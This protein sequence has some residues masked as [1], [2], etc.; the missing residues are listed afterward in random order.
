MVKIKT[1]L[2]DDLRRHT[3]DAQTTLAQL[4]QLVRAAYDIPEAAALQMR[5]LD[6]DG[7]LISLAHDDDLREAFLPVASSGTLRIHLSATEAP[8]VEQKAAKKPKFAEAEMEAPPAHTT[9]LQALRSLAKSLDLDDV[10]DAWLEKH[11]EM[12]T[13]TAP[14]ARQFLSGGTPASPCDVFKHVFKAQQQQQQQHDGQ[15]A[16]DAVHWGV[17][18]DV[19]GMSPIVGVRFHKRGSDYDLC[20]SEF[21]KLS[22]AEQEAFERIEAP[23]MTHPAAACGFAPCSP[24]TMFSHIGRMFGGHCRRAQQQQTPCGEELPAAPLAFGASG[25]GVEQ[26]QRALI[27][28]GHLQ[29]SAIR[30]RAGFF[31][32]LTH[33]AIKK[34]QNQ[35]GLEASGTMDDALR[36]QLLAQL[37]NADAPPAEKKPA[38][39]EETPAAPEEATPPAPFGFAGLDADATAQLA[40]AL[41]SFK[42]V[43]LGNAGNGSAEEEGVAASPTASVSKDD[44]EKIMLLCEMGFDAHSAKEAL[45]ATKGSVERAADRLFSEFVSVDESPFEFVSVPSE[46]EE[47]SATEEQAAAAA[48][49]NPPFEYEELLANLSEMGFD[50]AAGRDALLQTNGAFKEAVK[51][52]VKNERDAR[53][54]D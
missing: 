21:L 29:E 48:F 51:L 3:V 18:C 15:P 11:A 31:G 54:A 7:D 16:Q 5:Y 43:F 49:P 26:L 33:S 22:P 1:Q 30:W 17:T 44:E 46:S 4:E 2:N 24:R 38:A 41:G 8:A 25:P 50:E 52:L 6:E 42:G 39:S 47:I 45:I 19:S 27:R 9:T 53:N 14:F 36:E 37:R 40:A 28:L 20:E 32:P 23:R 35:L 13:R 34:L 10:P 12:L